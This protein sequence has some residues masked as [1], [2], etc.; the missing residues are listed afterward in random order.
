MS[1]YFQD[2]LISAYKIQTEMHLKEFEEMRI[3]QKN[4]QDQLQSL[5][6]E[7]LRLRA[8]NDRLGGSP[9]QQSVSNCIEIIFY[10]NN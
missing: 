1:N 3:T 9:Q 2:E 8:E 7:N 10:L 6:M 5:S 4:M